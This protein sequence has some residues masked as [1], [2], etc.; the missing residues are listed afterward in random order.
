MLLRLNPVPVFQWTHREFTAG[1]PWAADRPVQW[2][3]VVYRMLAESVV[4]QTRCATR[5]VPVESNDVPRKFAVGVYARAHNRYRVLPLA[6]QDAWRSGEI[7]DRDLPWLLHRIEGPLRISDY[8]PGLLSRVLAAYTLI[9]GIVAVG[10]QLLGQLWFAG[11]A[12]LTCCLFVAA[13][14]FW[15]QRRERFRDEWIRQVKLREDAEAVLSAPPRRGMGN[16]Q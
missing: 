11:V 7:R 1:D 6:L 9:F 15:R 16:S 8:P 4:A 5:S 10:A 14:M 2:S 3:V 12:A 13:W